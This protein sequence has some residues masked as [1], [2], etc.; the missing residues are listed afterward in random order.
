MSDLDQP[1][2]SGFAAGPRR[3]VQRSIFFSAIERYGNLVLFLATTAVLARLLTPA[4]FGIYAV[5]NAITAVVAASFQEFGGANYLIQK[6][7]LSRAD[8]RSAFTV[9]FAI[10]AVIGLALLALSGVLSQLFGQESLRKG[11]AVSALSFLL[12]PFSGTITGLF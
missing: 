4:E 10:S 2:Q 7:D 6:R 3:S 11:I 5:V 9:T 8:V 12:V 1:D